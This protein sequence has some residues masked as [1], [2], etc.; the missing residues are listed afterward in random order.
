MDV[1]FGHSTMSF[2]YELGDRDG[3]DRLRETYGRDGLDRDHLGGWF[4]N[5]PR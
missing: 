5:D 1:R 4:R 3:L 2:S